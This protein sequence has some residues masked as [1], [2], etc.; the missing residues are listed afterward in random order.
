MLVFL[1]VDGALGSHFSLR[2]ET[3][4]REFTLFL[5]DWVFTHN[6]GWC[7]SIR[8]RYRMLCTRRAF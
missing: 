1:R 6:S 7:H 5:P 2:V 8:Q 4:V 3:E